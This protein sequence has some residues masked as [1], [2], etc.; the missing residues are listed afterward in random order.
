MSE[1]DFDSGLKALGEPSDEN[2]VTWLWSLN[3]ILMSSEAWI[4]LFAPDQ[5]GNR[6]ERNN[7]IY[8]KKMERKAA[9]L[10]S[11]AAGAKNMAITNPYLMVANATG[12]Y[13]AIIAK[14]SSQTAGTRFKSLLKMMMIKKDS[15]KSWEAACERIE[16]ALAQV[17]RLIPDDL[18][19]ENLLSEFALF[20]LINCIDGNDPTHRTLLGD[21]ELSW[22]KAKDTIVNQ[23]NTSPS[24]I[25]PSSSSIFAVTNS[26]A[27]PAVTP[28]LPPEIATKI[29]FADHVQ[30][31]RLC[32][33]CEKPGH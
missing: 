32:F 26:A 31:A 2:F 28:P 15:E 18:T 20:V 21:G 7:N 5:D 33:F 4:T 27:T 6:P 8:F 3:S 13:D 19:I 17:Q 14:Y 1:I 9:A 12:M 30:S 23:E 16:Q 11:R 22:E 10:I 25:L 24:Q 29:E